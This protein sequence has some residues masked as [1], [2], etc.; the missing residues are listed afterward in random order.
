[1]TALKSNVRIAVIFLFRYI[2][3]DIS[4]AGS[5]AKHLSFL[6][7]K[8]SL[9]PW[10]NILRVE[11]ARSLLTAE[12]PTSPQW[13]KRTS[14]GLVSTLA[15]HMMCAFMSFVLIQALELGMIIG[16]VKVA[17]AAGMTI[18]FENVAGRSGRKC[19]LAS[20]PKDGACLEDLVRALLGKEKWINC[21]HYNPA[22]AHHLRVVSD[23]CELSFCDVCWAAD[24]K[25]L[26]HCVTYGHFLKDS[27]WKHKTHRWI[28]RSDDC[29]SE[30]FSIVHVF[31]I[32]RFE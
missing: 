26:M 31:V 9:A 2:H 8:H 32:A 1:M 14:L 7:L 10:M 6:W 12:S 3:H 25:I 23:A 28:N 17:L 13:Q 11:Q 15:F 16:F 30:T 29:I 22:Y 20:V 21:M 24:L 18:G 27:E 4:T 5:C 19:G